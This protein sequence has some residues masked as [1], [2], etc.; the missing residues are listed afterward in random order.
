MNVLVP[1]I[2]AILA[3]TIF[4]ILFFQLRSVLIP[5]YL[6][7]TIL[8]S[9]I[10]SLAA[11]SLIFYS[12]LN[13]PILVYVPLFVVVTTMGVGVDYGVFFVNRVREEVVGGNRNHEAIANAVDKVWVTILGLGLVLSAVFACLFISRIGIFEELS[14]AIAIA[15]LLAIA[16]GMLFFV[17]AVMGLTQKHNWWPYKRCSASNK[18]T[19]KTEGANDEH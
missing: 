9:I 2:T 8:S 15:V 16:V 13:L 6:V 3:A 11:T 4:F 17:P 7:T 1:E 10:L 14:L 12:G 18:K 19:V 5:L